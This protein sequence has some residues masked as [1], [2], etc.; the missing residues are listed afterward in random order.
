MAA[1]AAAAAASTADATAGG[2]HVSIVAE[3]ND[4]VTELS[5]G[6]RG[7]RIMGVPA[8]TD[9]AGNTVGM[10]AATGVG[11]MNLALPS[12]MS[13][14]CRSYNSLLQF[15]AIANDRKTT[16]TVSVWQKATSGKL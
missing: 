6:T 13:V 10:A 12:A 8:G 7:A 4:D 5:W 2:R 9:A 16:P 3:G 1:A 11:A 14:N 15:H